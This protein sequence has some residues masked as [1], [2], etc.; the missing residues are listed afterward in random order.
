MRNIL[1]C[2]C[3]GFSIDQASNDVSLFEI[4]DQVAALRYPLGLQRLSIVGMWERDSSE[5]DKFLLNYEITNNG[6]VIHQYGSMNLF[7]EFTTSRSVHFIGGLR[8]PDPGEVRITGRYGDQECSWT[9]K[10]I[11]VSRDD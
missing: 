3:R 9:F 4:V 7:G 6:N 5:E 8:I 1:F 10:A 2:C 11:L